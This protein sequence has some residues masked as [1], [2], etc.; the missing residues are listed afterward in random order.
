M[1]G[2][3]AV[4]V[5]NAGGRLFALRDVCPH[6]GAPLSSGTVLGELTARGPGEYEYD[7]ECRFVRCPWHGWEY[8][9]ETGQSSYDPEHDRVRAYAVTVERG[10]DLV[11]DGGEAADAS[12]RRPGPYVVETFEVAVRDDYVVLEM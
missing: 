2:R 8:S 11:T 12:G 5:F 1:V 7:P 10:A 3:R 9:L 4:A 6:Q